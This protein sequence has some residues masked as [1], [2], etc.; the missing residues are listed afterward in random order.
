MTPPRRHRR[1]DHSPKPPVYPQM[2]PRIALALAVVLTLAGCG[3][4]PYVPQEYPLRAGLIPPLTTKG[5]VAINNT[6][7]STDAAIVYSYGGTSFSSNYKDISQ[8]L[9][10]QAKKEIGKATTT[11]STG[12]AKVIDVKVVFLKSR[13]IAFFW[14]SELKFVATLGGSVVIEKTVNHGSGNVIQDLNGCIAESVM[15][16]LNDPKVIAYLAE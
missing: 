4:V 3:T 13:Y 12:A 16:L 10:D 15:V 7:S 8:L 9:V 1:P 11:A 2:N 6:Q 14:K 5:E